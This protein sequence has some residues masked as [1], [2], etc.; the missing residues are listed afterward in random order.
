MY[1]DVRLISVIAYQ[2]SM[3]VPMK[4][5]RSDA[6]PPPMATSRLIN[7]FAHLILHNST[8]HLMPK[9]HRILPN[10]T[11]FES[12][13]SNELQARDLTRFLEEDASVTTNISM[14]LR[15]ATMQ[16]LTSNQPAFNSDLISH[17]ILER[18]VRQNVKH[19]DFNNRAKTST[20]YRKHRMSERFILI[21]EG[22]VTVTNIGKVCLA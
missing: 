9:F 3:R 13:N 4:G 11:I 8:T 2:L 21:L 14:Q 7:D 10:M 15:L 16:W 18:L 20:L 12:K 6:H 1:A 17:P 22:R 19:V 5:G